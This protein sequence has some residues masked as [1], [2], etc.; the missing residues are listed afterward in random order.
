MNLRRAL[1]KRDRTKIQGAA[2]L[3]AVIILPTFILIF[4]GVLFVQHLWEVRQTALITARRCAWQYSSSGCRESPPGCE[5]VVSSR[6]SSDGDEQTSRLIKGK[7]LA[8]LKEL[9]VIGTAIEGL[10]GGAL[11]SSASNTVTRPTVLG[12]GAARV[13]GDFY[14]LCNEREREMKEVLKTMFFGFVCKNLSSFPGC[15]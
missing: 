4:A 3:E 10:F 13:K 12:G 14:L 15:N 9:P 2:Y 6:G 11:N 7:M 8:G 1:A 5:G